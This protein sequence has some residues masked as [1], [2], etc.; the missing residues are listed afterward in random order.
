VREAMTIAGHP[1]P[2]PERLHRFHRNL[3]RVRVELRLL[4]H[5]LRPSDELLAEDV[6]RRL[7]RLARLVGEVRDFDVELSLLAH[8]RLAKSARS[9]SDHLERTRGRL[10]EE[11]RTGR[12]LLGA[13][14][15]AELDRGLVRDL[16]RVLEAARPRLSPKSIGRAAGLE[17]E[18][19]RERAERALKRARRQPTPKRMH[20][21]RGA[22]RQARHLSDLLEA[23]GEGA[24]KPF[25][26]RVD[27]LQQE[28][29]RLHDLDVLADGLESLGPDVWSSSWARSERRR[30][31]R[32]REE[33]AAELVRR[34]VRDSVSGLF[35]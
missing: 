24:S 11:A 31:R 4:R 13:F 20:G 6:G 5:V 2:S 23:P 18:R 30:R 8:P 12:A 29:G 15:R 32:L 25:P 35:E 28:L 17:R 33:I 34:A 26:G 14:L 1:N 21:L 10:R 7:K 19:S 9:S 22:L 3:R 27:R 16:E